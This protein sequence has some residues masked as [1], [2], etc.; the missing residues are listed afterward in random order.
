[1]HKIL[2]RAAL[3]L[4]LMGNPVWAADT[5]TAD[6]KIIQDCMAPLDETGNFG[7]KCIGLIADPCIAQLQ[8]SGGEIDKITACAARELKVWESLMKPTL[9][10][11]AKAGFTDIKK[12]VSATQPKWASSRDVLCPFFDKTELGPGEGGST[13]CKLQET[14]RRVRLLRSLGWKLAHGKG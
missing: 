8:K 6:S 2:A 11:I 12:G 13:Y 14:A 5:L 10:D 4:L 3:F 7:A 1:L 9:A